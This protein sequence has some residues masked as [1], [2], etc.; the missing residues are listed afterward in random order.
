M[1]IVIIKQHQVEE[2]LSVAN[3]V[4][5]GIVGNFNFRREY[6]AFHLRNLELATEVYTQRSH[7]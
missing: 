7:R 2:R 1:Y 3:S 6:I 5:Y 4:E